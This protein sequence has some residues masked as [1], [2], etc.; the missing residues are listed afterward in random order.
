MKIKKFD[1]YIKECYMLTPDEN[2]KPTT[3]LKFCA[4]KI[5]KGD[6]VNALFTIY[7]NKPEYI[8]EAND[9]A[10]TD[11]YYGTGSFSFKTDDMMMIAKWNGHY[12][13][14]E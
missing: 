1:N 4:P 6:K 9:D 8:V 3:G 2:G 12:W 11:D 7:K 5:K 13:I 10:T 14:V